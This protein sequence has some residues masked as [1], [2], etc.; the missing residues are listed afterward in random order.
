MPSQPSALIVFELLQPYAPEITS[1][2]ALPTGF[3]VRFRFKKRWFAT[4]DPS[5]LDSKTGL[6][7]L[8]ITE[9]TAIL[10][11][12]FCTV[13]RVIDI[14]DIFYFVA[15]LRDYVELSSG[16]QGQT[17]Q[18]DSFN[19]SLR[20]GPLHRLKNEPGAG[21]EKLVFLGPSFESHF[22][23]NLYSGSEENRQVSAWG[24]LVEILIK[25]DGFKKTNFLRVLSLDD[26]SPNSEQPTTANSSFRLAA[27]RHYR[28]RVVQRRAEVQPVT[29][30]VLTLDRTMLL[31]I[32][33]KQ[34]AVGAYDI[35]DFS[36]QTAPRKGYE[37]R[38]LM[39][40]SAETGE[41]APT[42]R[43]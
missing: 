8:R 42:L 23:N 43:R 24:T 30:F 37:Q 12:R 18:L 36:F 33:A 32:L 10:P 35:L 6:I 38:T 7:A 21:M 5:K 16:A 34:R 2:L 29:D 20:D 17:Q 11:L 41:T 27:E 19:G 4:D 13:T 15:R 3:D 39:V 28:L 9:N 1:V 40:L 22:G 31:P 14:G 26:G 25:T